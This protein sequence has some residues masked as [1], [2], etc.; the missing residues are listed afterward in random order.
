TPKTIQ[1]K[2]ERAN[3]VYAV[4]IKINNENNVLKP[5]MPADVVLD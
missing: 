2:K 1:T 4:K 5:G 3:I